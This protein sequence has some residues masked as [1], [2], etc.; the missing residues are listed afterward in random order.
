MAFP[1]K[2]QKSTLIMLKI[3][4]GSPLIKTAPRDS[5]EL[6]IPPPRGKGYHYVSHK[7]LP[8][9]TIINCLVIRVHCTPLIDLLGYYLITYYQFNAII[10]NNNPN[11]YILDR[12]NTPTDIMV[13]EYCALSLTALMCK[14][15]ILLGMR[16]H[17][18]TDHDI[19]PRLSTSSHLL[20]LFLRVLQGSRTSV[21]TLYL[22]MV[23]LQ[24]AICH[25]H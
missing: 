6:C 24:P 1:T 16:F 12:I 19:F 2:W 10:L 9:L 8:L 20:P 25:Q 15:A 23:E 5:H 4:L 18:C 14:L 22:D 13:T 7:A 21:N 17:I 11:A 3:E